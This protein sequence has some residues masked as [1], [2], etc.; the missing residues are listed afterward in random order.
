MVRAASNKVV[1]ALRLSLKQKGFRGGKGKPK[2]KLSTRKSREKLGSSCSPQPMTVLLMQAGVYNPEQ[3]RH[4]KALHFKKKGKSS[5]ARG[6]VARRGAVLQDSSCEDEL[7]A[8]DA[9][10]SAGLIKMKKAL[11]FQ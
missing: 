4:L 5:A 9:V 11:A 6:A 7:I 10:E 8:A 2:R 1:A 3:A